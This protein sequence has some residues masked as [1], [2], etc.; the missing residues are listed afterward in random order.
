MARIKQLCD[1]QVAW[2]HSESR[3]R[4]SKLN[5]NTS[6]VDERHIEIHTPRYVTV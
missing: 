1:H 5:L 4:K 6:R 3:D 2:L